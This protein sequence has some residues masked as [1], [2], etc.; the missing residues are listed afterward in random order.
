MPQYVEL[1]NVAPIT[2]VVAPATTRA[3][4]ACFCDAQPVELATSAIRTPMWKRVSICM[5]RLSA[6]IVP[7]ARAPDSGRPTNEI[8]AAPSRGVNLSIERPGVRPS[9]TARRHRA[10]VMVD[11]SPRASLEHE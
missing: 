4:P 6:Y 7:N 5:R 11:E 2:V 8:P 10:G 9:R 1:A 3:W